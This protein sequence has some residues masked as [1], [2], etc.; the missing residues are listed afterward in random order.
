MPTT[1]NQQLSY[2]FATTASLVAGYAFLLLS[3][4]ISI[5]VIIRKFFG[6]SFQGV[7]EM[8]GYALAIGCAFS[9]GYALLLRGHTRVDIL[10]THL[11]PRLR[12]LLNV[13]AAAAMG[14]FAV[15]MA[16]QGW[17]A[18]KET[19][20]FDSHASTPLQTPLWIP[21]TLWV[22][23]M[24]V[25]ALLAVL[26]AW[27]GMADLLHGRITHIN[28][29]LDPRSTDEELD[30]A[31]ENVQELRHTQPNGAKSHHD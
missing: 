13:V 20:E 11:P 23:G 6:I 4:M 2:R 24:V 5:E 12:A 25:F 17:Q 27:R 19:I 9:F 30:E 22:L 3:V 31:L 16:W 15:F 1:Q 8:G 21:Q 26:L 10:L 29:T 14:I 7:D 18:L 28:S